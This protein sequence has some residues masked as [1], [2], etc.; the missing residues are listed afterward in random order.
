M[1]VAVIQFASL[2]INKWIAVDTLLAAPANC[3]LCHP[4]QL[5]WMLKCDADLWIHRMETIT[6]MD[7]VKVEALMPKQRSTLQKRWMILMQKKKNLTSHKRSFSIILVRSELYPICSQSN[8]LERIRS[9]CGL[10]RWD[11]SFYPVRALG[12]GKIYISHHFSVWPQDFLQ[13][14]MKIWSVHNISAQKWWM[15]HSGSADV[16][17]EFPQNWNDIVWELHI[18]RN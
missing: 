17:S 6:K 18:G 4:L 9:G 10:Q 11:Y 5:L 3:N 8:P 13:I 16:I 14:E 7:I 1:I 15:Y 12:S 2:K